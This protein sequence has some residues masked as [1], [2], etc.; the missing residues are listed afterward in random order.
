MGISTNANL[1]QLQ[2]FQNEVVMLL[3]SS[4]NLSATASYLV[5]DSCQPICYQTSNIAPIMHREYVEN[6]YKVDPLHP[7]N[8]QNKSDRIVRMSDLIPQGR[9]ATNAYY[10]DFVTQW[11]MRDIVELFYYQD[12][13]MIG[14][15]ALF[16]NKASE[17]LDREG[18]KR[19]VG[20]HRYIEF[21]LNKQIQTNTKISYE[22]F[23]QQHS[24]TNKEKVIL[25]LA[26]QGL[27]N[28]VIA[29]NLSSSLPTV[30][31]HLQHLFS[32]LSVNSK[33]EMVNKVY[34]A[35]CIL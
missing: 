14:G 4:F 9:Q 17:G 21:S 35:N 3:N 16:F 15:S 7:T 20:L 23:C 34:S 26:I 30:K 22:E 18:L 33:I 24:L 11:N 32:K 29:N 13:N 10:S 25:Q 27:A 31:T 1:V 19:L 8:F 6:F 5:D 28:K 2:E 12:G